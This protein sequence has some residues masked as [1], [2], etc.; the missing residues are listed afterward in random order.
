[1]NPQRETKIYLLSCCGSYLVWN[2]PPK[3]VPQMKSNIC[4]TLANKDLASLWQRGR[5]G[6]YNAG[7]VFVMKTEGLLINYDGKRWPENKEL[8]PGM[9]FKGARD[10]FCCS[11]A[12]VT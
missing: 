8:L 2:R 3:R 5:T 11:P 1:M 4:R 7:A 10:Q 6:G 9:T 12:S